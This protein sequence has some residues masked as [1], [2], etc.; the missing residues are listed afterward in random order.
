MLVEAERRLGVRFPD[1]YRQFIAERSRYDIAVKRV[2]LLPVDR[3]DW[4]D[5]THTAVAIGRSSIDGSETLCFKVKRGVASDAV[6]AWDG[7]RFKRIPDFGELVMRERTNPTLDTDD[8]V[9]LAER[10]GGASRRCA[11]GRE[12]KVLQACEC[13]RI[14]ARSD[15]TYV[16]S[17]AEQHQAQQAFPTLVR[18]ARIVTALKQAGH[19]V[20]SGPTQ[21]V[22]LAE[23]LDTGATAATLLASWKRTGMKID[24]DEP[25]IARVLGEV[26]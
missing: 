11:C 7:E 6:H 14:G 2:S 22:A 15:P 9:R 19:A 24:L 3:C 1:S 21:L 16:L 18:A 23:L 10:L 25:T 5:D 26:R 13:G 20:P 4:L 17:D 12:I 8:R